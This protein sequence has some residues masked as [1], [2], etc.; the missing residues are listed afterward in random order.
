[1]DQDVNIEAPQHTWED[2]ALSLSE[3]PSTSSGRM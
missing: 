2:C 3:R 1:M